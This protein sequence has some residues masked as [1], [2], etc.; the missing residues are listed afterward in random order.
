M[1]VPPKVLAKIKDVCTK[2]SLES[3]KAMKELALAI[4]TMTRRPSANSHVENSKIASKNL[5]S[6]LN[7]GIWEE[8]DLL[9]MMPVATVVSLLLDIV[10]CVEDIAEAVHEL[11]S[12]AYFKSID[13]N[14][15]KE[16][17]E[18][19]KCGVVKLPEKID[20]CPQVVIAIDG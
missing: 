15:N 3:G 14:L 11:A 13:L 17:S 4:K 20:D 2:I 7:S 9:K 6:L 10:I 18:L 8:T 5:K 12:L 19:E 1:Q 16:K